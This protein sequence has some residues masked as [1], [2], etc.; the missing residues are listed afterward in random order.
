M[1]PKLASSKTPSPRA[2]R[3]STTA[4]SAC[5][6]LPLFIY[7]PVRLV[8]ARAHTCHQ[9]SYLGGSW[10][11]VG[12]GATATP[13]Q[14]LQVPD[15]LVSAH[16]LTR[17]LCMVILC[18]ALRR[19]L[20]SARIQIFISRIIRGT[21]NAYKRGSASAAPSVRRRHGR[22]HGPRRGIGSDR[23]AH[24]EV[25]P[26]RFDLARAREIA[27]ETWREHL[28]P[29][30]RAAASRVRCERPRV[31]VASS[32]GPVTRVAC[33]GM[34]SCRTA[35]LCAL[36]ESRDGQS[37][38]VHGRLSGLHTGRA[39]LALPTEVIFLKSRRPRR[40]SP[41]SPDSS[42][43]MVGPRQAPSFPADWA[44]PTRPPCRRRRRSS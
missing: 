6:A 15:V 27:C 29:L 22:G 14:V 42:Y 43:T 11:G 38:R 37:R 25:H 35:R 30:T 13:R 17:V 28:S 20:R 3:S 33:A 19:A 8:V 23:A 1:H 32:R 16:T 18:R 36:I 34:P 12:G 4:E 7:S 9:A 10:Q 2:P 5:R 44:V 31:G 41:S 26:L 40:T 39:P 21:V 24:P